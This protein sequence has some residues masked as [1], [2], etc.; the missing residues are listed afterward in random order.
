MEVLNT[1][2]DNSIL[3]IPNVLRNKMLK[4][5]NDNKIFKNI[6]IMTFN[7]LK[8]GLLFDYTNQTINYIIN[9]LNVSYAIALEYINSLYYIDDATKNEKMG[10]LINLKDELDKNNLL[11][12]DSLFTNLIKSKNTIYVFGFN[13]I[14]KF[15]NHLLNKASKLIKVIHLNNVDSSYPHEVLK[16]NSMDIEIKYVAERISELIYHGIDLNKIY[17]V[18]YNQEYNFTINTI[19]KQFGIP[20]YLPSTENLYSTSIAKYFINH[21]DKNIDVL[22]Y[23]L[24]KVFKADVIKENEL[25]INKINNLINNYYWCKDLQSVKYLIIEEMKK[26]KIQQP[27]MLNEIKITELLNN[28]F[29]EDEYVFLIGFNDSKIP[30]FKKDE[31]Y[32]DDANKP[33]FVGTSIE[34]NMN[35]KDAT[36]RAIKGIK[37]L[38]ITY[39]ISSNFNTYLPSYLLRD[40]SLTVKHMDNFISEYSNAS[41]KLYLAEALDNYLKYNVI[42]PNLDKLKSLKIDYKIYNNQFSGIENEKL[43]KYLDG[44][45]TLS[46]S[47]LNDFYK[48]PYKFYLSNVLKL[49][50]YEELF[51]AFV[52]S[53]FHHCLQICLDTDI[54]VVS[55]YDK[56]IEDNYK[57]PTNKEAFF[58][59]ILREE[60]ITV[61]RLIKEQYKHSKHTSVLVEKRIEFDVDKEIRFK[62][63]G[64]V[65]KLLV[66]NNDVVIIDY[67]T[68][69]TKMSPERFEFG[70]TIQLPI[71]LYL[72][73][74]VEPDKNICGLYLQHILSKSKMREENKNREEIISNNLKLSGLTLNDS[75]KNF[76]DTYE[77]S[78][79]ISGLREKNGELVGSSVLSEKETTNLMAL[80]EQLLNDAMDKIIL[81]D[82][83]IN[84]IML[85]NE[86]GC[87]N[88]LY[89][90]IC[91]R[92]PSDFNYQSTKKEGDEDE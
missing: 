71:Y 18:N 85:D 88:C 69:D 42:D 70:S 9:N 17:I 52:G 76:D 55:T 58:L 90:D 7:E 75:I 13:N 84:P 62:I 87:N 35:I 79:I 59:D 83:K 21:L 20:V 54:G 38:T 47:N 12:Y 4:Y 45:I 57:N 89:K 61:V 22:L 31:D 74:V 34:E 46:Y 41:N 51:E 81:G 44:N 91:Y 19:F 56:Y 86:S 50:E 37:N 15:N 28:V 3:I 53:L 63:K 16:F 72:L 11:E 8:K 60:V 77:K 36:L 48:C 65:D 6:K 2:E 68:N 67:K 27:H 1:I 26:T 5:F 92:R 73:K 25:I 14:S 33:E 32:L 39:P 66:F 64:F 43:K 10:F 30:K 80:M 49:K 24:R 29:S 82:F 23:E 40:E 78:S